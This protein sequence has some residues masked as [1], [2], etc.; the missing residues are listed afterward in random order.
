MDRDE[1]RD[2]DPTAAATEREDYEP[3]ELTEHPEWH[4]LTG[5]MGSG[6]P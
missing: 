1:T 4:I 6:L 5:S 3:P 2:A